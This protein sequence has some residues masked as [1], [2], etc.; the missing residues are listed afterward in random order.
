MLFAK[1]WSNIPSPCHWQMVNKHLV[2]KFRSCT[3]NVVCFGS[4]QRLTQESWCHPTIFCQKSLQANQFFWTWQHFQKIEHVCP[5]IIKF[6]A[7]FLPQNNDD[8]VLCTR[9]CAWDDGADAKKTNQW[10]S[11][12]SIWNSKKPDKREKTDSLLWTTSLH[13]FLSTVSKSDS[14]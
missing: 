10:G 14:T 2:L 12:L 9:S 8:V 13:L 6:G 4:T 3:S 1:N 11:C 5:L 7:S